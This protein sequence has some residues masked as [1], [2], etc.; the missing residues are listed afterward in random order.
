M[1]TNHDMFADTGN[2]WVTS[3]DY[4]RE[5]KAANSAVTS[6][7]AKKSAKD[8]VRMPNHAE[9]KNPKRENP[10]YR[11][12]VRE[13]AP[14]S[15]HNRLVLEIRQSLKAKGVLKSAG[16]TVRKIEPVGLAPRAVNVVPGRRES[17]LQYSGPVQKPEPAVYGRL[18]HDAQATHE[19]NKRSALAHWD[20]MLK[21]WNKSLHQASERGDMRGIMR[22]KARINSIQTEIDILNL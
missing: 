4:L 7:A 8:F 1:R 3:D 20:L 14:I 18:E 15:E 9:W 12:P 13:P 2:P 6:T 17:E 10:N 21:E 19:S 22:A 16:R 11:D 5:E